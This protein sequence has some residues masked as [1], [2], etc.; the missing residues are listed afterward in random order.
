M[1][2]KCDR[3]CRNEAIREVPEWVELPLR[4]I[5]SALL[6]YFFN[7]SIWTYAGWGL[8]SKETVI[9]IFGFLDYHQWSWFWKG[10]WAS[11]LVSLCPFNHVQWCDTLQL[12]L[13]KFSEC[14]WSNWGPQT[15]RF[16]VILCKHCLRVVNFKAFMLANFGFLDN[17][18]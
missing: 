6:T 14:F 4:Q 17:L 12:H 3:T 9:R 18:P 7:V 15:K 11:N 2:Y 10:L 16:F 8:W 1:F 5:Q 13:V